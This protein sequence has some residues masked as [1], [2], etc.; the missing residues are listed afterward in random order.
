M[1]KHG[2]IKL[3]RV[4]EDN[5]IW[6]SEPMSRAQAFIDLILTANHKDGILFVRGN[7]IE[8]K[9]GQNARSKKNFA[10]RWQWSQGKVDRFLK[11]LKNSEQIDYVSSSETTIITITNYDKYQGN[12]DDASKN[13][14]QTDEQTVSRR[15]TDGEQTET[16][17]NDNNNKN[18]K[19]DKKRVETAQLEEVI[20]NTKITSPLAAL[21][22]DDKIRLWAQLN[23]SDEQHK[24]LVAQYDAEFLAN[25][26]KKAYF[27]KEPE[28]IKTNGL[29]LTNWINNA[30][31]KVY[32]GGIS[33]ADRRKKQADKAL[34]EFFERSGCKPLED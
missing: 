9:R 26:V 13:G 29:Y 14:E 19:N 22:S 18:V 24:D 28:F 4:I 17:K 21:I 10:A 20:K 30:R 8:V 5:E 27:Y 31:G 11:Y 12:D 2:W 33:E 3:H 23:G 15:R 34:I 7:K 32:A 6:F 16:N 1:S 25:E